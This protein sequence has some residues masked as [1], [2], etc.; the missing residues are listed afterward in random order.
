MGWGILPLKYPDSYMSGSIATDLGRHFEMPPVGM[1]R[2][3]Q[4]PNPLCLGP[5]RR[6]TAR[7]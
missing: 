5:T 7:K 2:T 1:S 4:N 3:G 6:T